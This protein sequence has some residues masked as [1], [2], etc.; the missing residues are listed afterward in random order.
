ML[1]FYCPSR[2]LYT[3]LRDVVDGLSYLHANGVVH[4]DLKGSNTLVTSNI[5]VV[6]C[7]FGLSKMSEALHSATGKFL[8]H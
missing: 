7:D 8:P 4:G 6:L 1:L 5:R 3:Q 2:S